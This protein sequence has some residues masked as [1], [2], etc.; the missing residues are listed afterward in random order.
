MNALKAFLKRWR[1]RH[2]LPPCPPTPAAPP[3]M[4][5]QEARRVA[6][7][8][9]A[10]PNEPTIMHAHTLADLYEMIA[11]LNERV[12]VMEDAAALR[13]VAGAYERTLNR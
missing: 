9:R 5:A 13:G 2:N 6:R 11:H 8:L 7:D 12:A 10:R 3:W 1:E 4:M